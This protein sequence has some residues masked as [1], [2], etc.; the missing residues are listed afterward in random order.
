MGT[1]YRMSTS[2]RI[3]NSL[4]GIGIFVFFFFLF[5]EDGINIDQK[6]ATLALP[7]IGTFLAAY[8]ITDVIKRKVVIA[9]YSIK[10]VNVFSTREI[11]FDAIKGCRIADKVIFIEPIDSNTST[12][13][14]SNYFE[15]ENSDSLKQWFKENFED[16][17]KIDL[18]NERNSA[19]QNKAFGDTETERSATLKNVKNISWAYNIIAFVFGFAAVFIEGNASIIFLLLYP[20]LGIAIMIFSKGTMKFL[21]NFKRSIYGFTLGGIFIP[22]FFLMIKSLFEYDILKYDNLWLPFLLI[23]AMFFFILYRTGINSAIASIRTQVIIMLIVSLIYGFGSTRI[24]N[25]SFDESSPKSIN[26]TV[27]SKWIEY[28]KGE[29]YHLRISS[30]DSDPKP[31]DCEVRRSTFDRYE[32]GNTIE[33]YVKPGLLHIPWFYI[34]K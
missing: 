28:N 2:S 33:V 22:G 7:L 16:Q 20:I 5:A 4:L 18:E 17:D 14:I 8:F 34:K 25:C 23:S 24:I 12:I 26:T 6:P 15:L 32:S 3:I 29:H 30:W 1:T 19:L 31:K 11:A 21:S 27:D 9:D 13:A 10:R